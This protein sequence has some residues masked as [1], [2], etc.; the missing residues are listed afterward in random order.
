MF[1]AVCTEKNQCQQQIVTN[2]IWG[3]PEKEKEKNHQF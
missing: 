2:T 1:K 3:Q